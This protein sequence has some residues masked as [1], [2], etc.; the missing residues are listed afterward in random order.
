MYRLCI[1]ISLVL[2]GCSSP[3][4]AVPPPQQPTY[5]SLQG[6]V[7]AP[8][9]ATAPE[10][11]NQESDPFCAALEQSDQSLLVNPKGDLKNA[12]IR[13]YGLPDAPPPSDAIIVRQQG[14]SFQPRIVPLI[15]GQTLSV[16]NDDKTFHNVRTYR[17]TKPL[18]S[19][20]HPPGAA[21]ISDSFQ[22]EKDNV[23]HMKCDIHPWMRGA[24]PSRPQLLRLRPMPRSGL[25]QNFRRSRRPQSP[26]D[27]NTESTEDT[28]KRLLRAPCVLCIPVQI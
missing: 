22:I 9:P 25:A 13:I 6:K 21:P 7:T 17:G 14:C 4:V 11:I 2:A 20:A 24:L 12:G 15:A 18:F 26:R 28:E 5:G 10:T 1:L 8:I 27:S 3:T 16:T 19:I 23:I